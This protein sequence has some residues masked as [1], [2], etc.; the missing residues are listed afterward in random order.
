M[1][2]RQSI[3]RLLAAAILLAAAALPA[4]AAKHFVNGRIAFTSTRDGNSEIYVMN[5]NGGAQTRLTDDPAEDIDAAW[6]PDGTRI[7]FARLDRHG[8]VRTVHVMNADGSGDTALAFQGSRRPAWSPDGKQIAFDSFR[9]KDITAAT[10][11][12]IMA[13]DGTNQTRLTEN[14]G[15]NFGPA[16]SPDGRSIAFT[17]QVDAP[18][19][20][21][22]ICVMN[23]D[24]TGIRALTE[25]RRG[26][27][28]NPSFSPDGRKIVFE[29][30][31]TAVSVRRDV[32]IMFHRPASGSCAI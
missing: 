19:G 28:L 11:I 23:P 4:G 3:I 1:S 20:P 18:L 16:W 30:F 14:D 24:G 9:D 2:I 12:Y 21:G 25:N 7:A 31:E 13:A 8:A 27:D 22:S 6:S 15:S 26:V 32:M 5:P 10:E 17:C 29:R